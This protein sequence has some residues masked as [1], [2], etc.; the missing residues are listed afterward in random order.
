[1][2]NK[3]QKSDAEWKKLL[4][5]E[6]YRVLREKGTERPFVNA[7]NGLH[8]HGIFKCAACGQELFS[9]DAK[10]DSGTGWP[11]FSEP[12]SRTQSRPRKTDRS[13]LLA[14]KCCVNVAAGTSVTSSMM[15]RARQGCGIA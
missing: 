7:Y 14:P 4:T 11:S 15:V 8:D 6:Q 1:M 10:F 5:P 12:I 3:I 9:S 13:S 2:E